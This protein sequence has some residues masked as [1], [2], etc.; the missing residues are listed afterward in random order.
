LHSVSNFFKKNKLLFV[1]FTVFVPYSYSGKILG[2]SLSDII[3]LSGTV[4][5][6]ILVWGIRNSQVSL[7]HRLDGH[8]VK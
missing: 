2:E 3:I 1:H 8:K 4:F 6:E 7:F 5:G